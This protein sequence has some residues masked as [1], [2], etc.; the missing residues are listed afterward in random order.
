[1]SIQP[2]DIILFDL[3]S[4]SSKIIKLSQELQIKKR[5]R[6]VPSSFRCKWS[7]VGIVVSSEWLNIKNGEEGKLYI[8][9]STSS[10]RF[11]FISEGEPY[12]VESNTG[13]IGLQIRDLSAVM[14]NY[15][16][17]GK[18]GILRLKPYIR[19]ILENEKDLVKLR[20]K[21]IHT[22]NYHQ[23][24][25]SPL[26]LLSA[27]FP[28]LRRFR[29]NNAR[30]FCS[31]FVA[32]VLERLKLLKP[33]QLPCNITP[34]DFAYPEYSEERFDIFEPT[35]QEIKLDDLAPNDTTIDLPDV[36]VNVINKITSNVEVAIDLLPDSVVNIMKPIIN[37]GIHALDNALDKSFDKI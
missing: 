3:N 4:F 32:I 18:F 11:K 8:W 22:K 12:D 24:Y 35:I 33:H 7:H 19:N 16:K 10:K 23:R 27:I 26:N 1:M 15:S 2:F 30:L 36:S 37:Q 13:L 21:D 20:L 29:A 25:E 9:E 14:K 17:K 31:E 6:N 28:S 5:H 34:S